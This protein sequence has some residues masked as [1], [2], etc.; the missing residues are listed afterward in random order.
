MPSI[1][2][3]R[4]L[5]D[6]QSKP[7][8]CTVAQLIRTWLKQKPGLTEFTSPRSV[9]P[10]QEPA[11]TTAMEKQLHFYYF[12]HPK[13]TLFQGW[14]WENSS[15]LKGQVSY[16]QFT[17]EFLFMFPLHQYEISFSQIGIKKKFHPWNFSVYSSTECVYINCYCR[18]NTAEICNKRYK[19]KPG[20]WCSCPVNAMW[21]IPYTLCC[22]QLLKC[23]IY[24]NFP[25]LKLLNT[26]YLSKSSRLNSWDLKGK[27]TPPAQRAVLIAVAASIYPRL[28]PF[29][30]ASYSSS[31]QQPL[32]K[33][34]QHRWYCTCFIKMVLIFTISAET[35]PPKSCIQTDTHTDTRAQR[36]FTLRG[37]E[38]SAPKS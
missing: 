33:V 37:C 32:D 14:R 9:Q 34:W 7:G 13:T 29:F 15:C 24:I 4:W 2:A 17:E 35:I 12:F 31:A 30:I 27:I 26:A 21:H 20:G 22:T 28:L 11:N 25:P 1:S 38:G 6:S 19:R 36:P 5:A 3:V 8:H 16:T 18:L 10:L 23:F